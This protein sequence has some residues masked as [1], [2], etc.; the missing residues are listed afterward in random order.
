MIVRGPGAELRRAERAG[1]PAGASPDRPGGGAGDAG[2]R[3]PGA[4][5]RDGGGD[6][7]HPQGRRCLPAAG[8]RLSGA[9]LAYHAGRRRPGACALLPASVGRLPGCGRVLAL[10]APRRGPRVGADRRT[11]RATESGPARCRPRHPA[12]VIYTSGSTGTPK[13]VVVDHQNV[14]TGLLCWQTTDLPAAPRIGVAADSTS[15]RF[16]FSVFEL[17]GALLHGGPVVIL[18]RSRSCRRRHRFWGRQIEQQAHRHLCS[19]SAIFSSWMPMT[20]PELRS[21]ACGTRLSRRGSPLGSR[22]CRSSSPHGC[23]G[24]AATTS[25]ARPRPRVQYLHGA[26]AAGRR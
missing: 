15:L 21:V 22:W 20:A 24:A 18:C 3:L 6:P 25:T 11:T 5:G 8:P 17:W 2:G 13:G 19:P 14:V 26:A 4:L 1:Q 7:G 9:R 10:D 23:H 16:D 12:Y